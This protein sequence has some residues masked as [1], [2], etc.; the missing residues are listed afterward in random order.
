MA[1]I[2]ARMPGVALGRVSPGR[3]SL[4]VRL[5]AA[6]I[7]CAVAACGGALYMSLAQA[8]S[9]LTRLGM[10]KIDQDMSTLWAL[11]AVR[12]DIRIEGD[13]LFF[14]DHRVNDDFAVVDQVKEIAG[15]GTATVFQRQ[16]EEFVRVSTNVEKPEGG[17]AVGTK[18]ARN[19][20]YESVMAGK[21]FRGRVDILGT[22]YFTGYDPIV[23]AGGQV[24]GIMY[25]GVKEA[26]FLAAAQEMALEASLVGAGILI[27]AI[28]VLILLV[29]RAL[30]PLGQMEAAMGSL[31]A[32]TTSIEIPGAGRGDEIGRMAGALAVFR[33]K[34][35]E[36]AALAAERERLEAAQEQEQLA[37]RRRLA[38][39]FDSLTRGVIA[40]LGESTRNLRGVADDLK[41]TTDAT[42]ERTR[43]VATATQET[44][45]SMQTVAASTE[46]LSASIAEISQQVTRSADD[47]KAAVDQAEQTNA[48]VRQLDESAQKIGEVVSLINDIASQ[49]NLLALNATI[50]AARAGEM[51]KGFAV[52]ANEVKS[53]ANQTAK[54]TE[55]I[56]RQVGEIQSATTGAVAAIAGIGQTIDSIHQGA[57]AIAAA[58]EEQGAATQEIARNV[59]HASSA[60]QSIAGTIGEVASATQTSGAAAEHMFATVEGLSA[61][62][63]RLSSEIE[64]FVASMRGAA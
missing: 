54:A 1:S 62:T 64:R 18:L 20:A 7:V 5:A 23:D 40:S 31:A 11:A 22:P 15:G 9:E 24:V 46:E 16:G 47:A 48:L 43:S 52:V 33:D 39:E 59:Q 2:F 28:G 34:I 63:G 26:E 53:L 32:G 60:S 50:E 3:L 13:A 51:G 45:L 38:D 10:Q 19:A 61:E 8:E 56:S 17:R 21:P 36:N 27:V 42:S 12:G 37:A 55:D 41:S 25:V 49:T 30:K 14:G 4:S 44:T 57:S 58:V 35:A 6:A 29:R